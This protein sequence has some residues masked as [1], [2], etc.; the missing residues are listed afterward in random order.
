MYCTSPR[1]TKTPER[2]EK[3]SWS[4]SSLSNTI[5]QEA[6]AGVRFSR[7]KPM[8][9]TQQFQVLQ[10]K[11]EALLLAPYSAV[12]ETHCWQLYLWLHFPGRSNTVAP[13]GEN[14]VC[15]LHLDN[16]CTLNRNSQ[17]NNTTVRSEERL[18]TSSS[19]YTVLLRIYEVRVLLEVQE[20]K[21]SDRIR[22]HSLG[23]MPTASCQYSIHAGSQRAW[24]LHTDR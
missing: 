6:Q 2:R 11:W 20:E 5:Q 13:C 7:S 24:S 12:Q 21:D 1:E 4:G 8:T 10:L 22:R 19:P 16:N 17:P 14:E 3:R 23:H 18:V 9:Q 15:L